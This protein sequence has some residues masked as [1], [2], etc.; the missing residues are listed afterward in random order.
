MG[1]PGYSAVVIPVVT[2]DP[3][4]TVV[5]VVTV[6]PVVTVEEVVAGTAAS[7]RTCTPPSSSIVGA[8]YRSAGRCGASSPFA[9]MC[10]WACSSCSAACSVPSAVPSSKAPGAGSASTCT[11]RLNR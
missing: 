11:S 3:V 4:V 1:V 2:V 6:D 9:T 10:G 8:V 7:P 5:P